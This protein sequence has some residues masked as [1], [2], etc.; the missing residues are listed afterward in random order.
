[1]NS[2]VLLVG[3]NGFIGRHLAAELCRSSEVSVFDRPSPDPPRSVRFYPG[4]ITS[5]YDLEEVIAG[6]D[7]VVYLVHQTGTSP[8][9]DPDMLAVVRNIELF[10]LTLESCKNRGV[11]KI[12]LFSSGGA[13]Y[14]VPECMPIPECHPLAPISAYGICKAAMER[15]QEMFCRREGM[16]SLIVRPSNPYGVGQDYRRRQGVVAIF[17]HRILSGQ[18][19]E[20][21]GDGSATKDYIHVKDLA[22][23][24]AALIACGADGIFN[25]GSGRGT[26]LSELVSI[27]ESVA[28][29]GKA[30]LRFVEA[31]DTDVTRFVLDVSKLSATTG[32]RARTPLEVGIRSFIAHCL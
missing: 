10:L 8:Y 15:Y 11:R 9:L 25:I 26:S 12:V 21:W 14:G 27:I 28:G 5:S 4:D 24:V 22:E 3:G 13:V 16:Q 18:S 30:D 17:L 23:A 6:H 2:R 32:W 31:R 29:C 7:T 19:I 20:I 1:M